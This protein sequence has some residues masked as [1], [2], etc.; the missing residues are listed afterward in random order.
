MVHCMITSKAK[1]KFLEII[2]SLLRPRPL[3]ERLILALRCNFFKLHIFQIFEP[4]CTATI[5]DKKTFIV[6]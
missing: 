5:D 3:Q 1:S 4:H 2:P 6:T